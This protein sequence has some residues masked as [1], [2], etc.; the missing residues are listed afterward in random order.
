M[1]HA[2]LTEE[3]TAEARQAFDMSLAEPPAGSLV[4]PSQPEVDEK[5]M[6]E[7]NQAWLASLRQSGIPAPVIKG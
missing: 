1:A 2:L 4:G 7:Q 6:V 3:L 5:R